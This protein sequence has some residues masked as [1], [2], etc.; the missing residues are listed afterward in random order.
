MSAFDDFPRASFGGIEFPVEERSIKGSIRKHE[1]VYPHTPGAA[2]ET[3][4]RNLYMIH[5][6]TTFTQNLRGYPDLYPSALA[7]L[8]RMYETESRED[9]VVPGLGTIKAVCVDWQQR[10]AGKENR[11]GEKVQF[12]FEE[13]LEH[14]FIISNLVSISGQSLATVNK[15]LGVDIAA[16]KKAFLAPGELGFLDSIFESVNSV[17]A[18][19][20]TAEAYGNL[21]ETKILGVASLIYQADKRLRILND[22]LNATLLNSFIAV[23]DAL[24]ALF[25]DLQKT[26]GGV[27]TIIVNKITSVAEL[28]KSLYNGDGS[29]AVEIMQ[30]NAFE[31]PFHISPGTVVK[32]YPKAA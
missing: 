16:A 11:S 30:M 22:P 4:G 29:R 3:L 17:L 5:F 21:L 2:L 9:L 15:D 26:G 1:H 19:V 10:M 28:A 6:S 8:R 13:D 32:Y 7:R 14:A 12:E 25:A 31:N 18:I 24:R 23:W 27:Q 20:D